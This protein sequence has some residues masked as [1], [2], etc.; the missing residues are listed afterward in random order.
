[1]RKLLALAILSLPLVGVGQIS[2]ESPLKFAFYSPSWGSRSSAS[3]LSALRLVV[4]NQTGFPVLLESIEFTSDVENL[5]P[6]VVQIDMRISPGSLGERE[7]PYIDVLSL[8]QC[9]TR[10]LGDNWRL[11]EISN[12]TLNPSVRRLI[13]E[14]T[15]A[16]RIYQCISSVK[17]H[18]TNTETGET[19]IQ[20]E[21]VLYHFESRPE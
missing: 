12:Y 17:T 20:D 9:V 18:W 10:T 15:S 21:W 14:D 3:L 19:S 6:A 1:M 16:F 5:E 4:D 2:E 11:V 13:I 7:I 8:N